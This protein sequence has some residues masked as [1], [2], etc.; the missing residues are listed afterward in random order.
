MRT[1]R[2]LAAISTPLLIVACAVGT[3]PEGGGGV[4]GDGDG[5]TTSA[6]D[7]GYGTTGDG[8]P[9]T[10]TDSGSKI[11]SGA[12]KDGGITPIDS[13][14]GGTSGLDCSGKTSTSGESYE[15]EC[16]DLYNDGNEI[17]CTS[18]GGECGAGTC[19]WDNSGS[20]SF[21]SCDG[22]FGDFLGAQC[23]PQ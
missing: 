20:F 14:S 6:G 23:V 1:A 3:A 12:A 16:K 7:S 9:I 18:G 15:N 17:D 13:G 22:F 4:G 5:G 8:S 21:G 2:F 11:D 19:C 10:Q